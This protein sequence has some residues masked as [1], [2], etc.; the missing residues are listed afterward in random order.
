MP[1]DWRTSPDGV[2]CGEDGPP[3][4]VIYPQVDT[5]VMSSVTHLWFW[6]RLL[7]SGLY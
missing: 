1:G 2:V 4:S 3:P 5:F 6:V 7:V